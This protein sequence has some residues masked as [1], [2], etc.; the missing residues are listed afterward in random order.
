MDTWTLTRYKGPRRWLVFWMVMLM[1]VMVQFFS[2]IPLLPLSESNMSFAT[3]FIV[4]LF[5]LMQARGKKH[6]PTIQQMKPM[7]WLIASVLLSFIPAYLYFHQSAFQSFL[8]CRKFLCYLTLPLLLVSRPTKEELRYSFYIFTYIWLFT[9]IC[10]TFYLQSWV[11]VADGG[12]FIDEGDILHCLPGR[13]FVC[14]TFIFALDHY[15]ENR[16]VKT[17]LTTIFFFLC[18]F[19]MFSRT[20]LLAAVSVIVLA[21]LRGRT[22]RAKMAGLTSLVIFIGIFTYLAVD[23]LTMLI[24]ETSSQV[25]DLDYNRNKAFIYMFSS[26]RNILT[27]LLGN[28]FISG[29]VDSLIFDLQEQGIYYSDVGLVGMWNQFG[30][31]AVIVILGTAIKGLSRDYSFSV[32]AIS[33]FILVS[34]LTIGYFVYLECIFWLCLFWYLMAL[35]TDDVKRLRKQ[36]KEE[37]AIRR[38]RYRSINA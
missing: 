25:V 22:V 9:T 17:L 13:R 24:E 1:L 19:I 4:A 31:L 37:R 3:F 14:I 28:G 36:R 12:V 8:T 34:S 11:L 23:Q 33:V 18:V 5:I 21:T 7:L 2:L 10:V 20:M 6:K 16:S 15:L 29:H 26:Q 35:E 32:R 38:Q 30:I 27:I